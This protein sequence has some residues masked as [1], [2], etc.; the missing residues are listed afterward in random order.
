MRRKTNA[1]EKAPS[2]DSD[3]PGSL[4]RLIRAFAVYFSVNRFVMNSN[5]SNNIDVSMCQMTRDATKP[6]FGDSDQVRH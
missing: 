2:I 4:P 5:G 1:I 3:Q 6:V